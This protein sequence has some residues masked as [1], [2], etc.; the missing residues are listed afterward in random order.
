MSRGEAKYAI[1]A[2]DYFN[3]WVE[4][5]PLSTII[6]K[7]R[8]IFVVRNITTRYGTPCKIISDNNTQ[9]K[10]KEFMELCKKNVIVKSFSSVAHP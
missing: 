9:F 8:V 7:K 5:E 3:K 4:A 2:I 6:A 1:A 10:R